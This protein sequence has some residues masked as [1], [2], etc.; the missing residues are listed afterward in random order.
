MNDKE[1]NVP[2]GD[3]R[4][5]VARNRLGVNV[6]EA[7]EDRMTVRDENGSEVECD[8]GSRRMKKTDNSNGHG[9][10]KLRKS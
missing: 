5:M 6:Y 10:E 1:T 7:R 8:G 3:P 4:K 9:R 2:T